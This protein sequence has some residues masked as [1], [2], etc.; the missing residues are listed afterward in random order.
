MFKRILYFLSRSEIRLGHMVSHDIHPF[1]VSF[2]NGKG[3]LLWGAQGQIRIG[4]GI[5]GLTT[6]V[7]RSREDMVRYWFKGNEKSEKLSS[8]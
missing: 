1:S 5:G 8:T 7:V 6:Y 2:T 4:V 3:R